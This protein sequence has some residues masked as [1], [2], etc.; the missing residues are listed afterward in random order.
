MS[1]ELFHWIIFLVLIDC[2]NLFLISLPVVVVF[3]L[4]RIACG[5]GGV[6]KIPRV[7]NSLKDYGVQEVNCK[8]KW[9]RDLFPL[10]VFNFLNNTSFILKRNCS[11][12][13]STARFASLA[14]GKIQKWLTGRVF[15]EIEKNKI[16]FEFFC[17]K[18][19]ITLPRAIIGQRGTLPVTPLGYL[20]S[21]KW[22]SEL[23][24]PCGNSFR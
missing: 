13:H 8:Q 7:S 12:K 11:F 20:N 1:F 23:C 6:L 18:P 9:F 16:F 10:G 5:T 15:S 21:K 14:F 4:T 17:S 19:I 3:G 22:F 2:Q 24:G